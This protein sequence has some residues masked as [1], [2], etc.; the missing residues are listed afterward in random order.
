MDVLAVMTAAR[1]GDFTDN[2]DGTALVAGF[3][4]GEG[5]FELQLQSRDGEASGAVR[6]NDAVVVLDVE[7]TPELAAEGVARDLVRAL[8]DLRKERGF[9]VSD[10]IA[11][12]I[13]PD[14]HIAAALAAHRDWIAG[15]VLAVSLDHGPGESTLD[16]DGHAVRVT[17]TTS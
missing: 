1:A 5:E 7:V 9:D 14:D 6:S 13:E 3:L 11:L 4:L 17:I 10:R 12:T 15:E 2:G 16:V 8:N